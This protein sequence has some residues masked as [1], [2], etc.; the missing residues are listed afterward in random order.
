MTSADS[1]AGLLRFLADGALADVGDAS[2]DLAGALP[3]AGDAPA[4]LGDARPDLGD[5]Q[6]GL[7]DERRDQALPGGSRA[8][9]PVTRR[10]T[11]ASAS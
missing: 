2:A 9:S 10:P 6:P 3:D 11:A 8:R 1:A 5:A 4:D 7:V